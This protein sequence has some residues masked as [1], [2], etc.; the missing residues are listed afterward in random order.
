MNTVRTYID[1]YK[2]QLVILLTICICSSIASAFVILFLK[3]S[4]Q[5]ISI[6]EICMMASITSNFLFFVAIAFIANK[7]KSK[8]I[9]GGIE[10]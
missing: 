3:Y 7:Y 2:P 10:R 6:F 4:K 9:C 1:K 8:S 5:T